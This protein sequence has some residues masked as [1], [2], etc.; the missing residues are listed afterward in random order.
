[1]PK[2]NLDYPLPIKSLHQRYDQV[3][4]A[5][6]R[7]LSPTLIGLPLS[8][9]SAYFKFILEYDEKILNKFINTSK[10]DFKIIDS[11]KI[12]DA[13]LIQQIAL[14]LST[15]K[16]IKA[17][18][19]SNLEQILHTNDPL[20]IQT[21]L[22][23]TIKGIDRGKIVL[24]LF[25]ADEFLVNKPETQ[26]FLLNLAN[27]NRHNPQKSGVLFLTTGSPKFLDLLNQLEFIG[28]KPIFEDYIYY[29][30]LHSESELDYV[31]LRLEKF[32]NTKIE[33]RVHLVAKKLSFGHYILYKT[34]STLTYKQLSKITANSSAIGSILEKLYTSLQSKDQNNWS[35]KCL[36][37]Y[38]PISQ[39]SIFNLKTKLSEGK[40]KDIKQLTA[41]E[42]LLFEF[43]TEKKELVT[44]DQVAQKI[45]G[46]IWIEKYS[47]WAIDKLVSNLKKKIVDSNFRLLTLRNRGYRVIKYV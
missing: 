46:A 45:W 8:S 38:K 24:C 47:D 18:D 23:E 13:Q 37:K 17:P 32:R 15:S 43:L 2:I 7:S 35:W 40:L 33:N 14:T 16:F 10:F 21:K 34:L 25:D 28:L 19:R 5:L 3:F 31:K 42:A 4:D 22:T 30:A 9:R 11:K 27:I 39:S 6:T 12:T 1:M 36:A 41:Q 29:F 20:L 26:E 44:R